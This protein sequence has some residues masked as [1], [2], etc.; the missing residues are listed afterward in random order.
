VVAAI[1]TERAI[2]SVDDLDPV[3]LRRFADLVTRLLVSYAIS[4]P[5]DPPEIVAAYVARFL[6]NGVS[7]RFAT[8]IPGGPS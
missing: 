5:D 7:H 1:V 2:V 8:A 4:A 3:E 6:I